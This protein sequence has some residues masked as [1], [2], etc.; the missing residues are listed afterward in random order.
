MRALFVLSEYL[1]VPC[2]YILFICVQCFTFYNKSINQ[3]INQSIVDIATIFRRLSVNL[4]HCSTYSD[5]SHC[6]V[7]LNDMPLAVLWHIL[8]IFL[9]LHPFVF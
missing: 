5:K 1:N 6:P 2:I 3:S 7:F 4:R 8:M 9:V